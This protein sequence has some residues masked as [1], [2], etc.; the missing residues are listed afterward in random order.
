MTAPASAVAFDAFYRAE[1]AR[2]NGFFRRKVG[3]DEAA[4][5]TQEAFMRFYGS[6]RFATLECPRAYLATVARNIWLNRIRQQ[7]RRGILYPLDEERE[8]ATPP[9]QER[10]FEGKELRRAYWRALRPL[11]RKTRRIFL[12]HRLRGMTYRDIADELGISC[13]AVEKRIERALARCRKVAARH[14]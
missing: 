4:D 11:S 1:H 8:A 2:V 5:L 12:M 14:T 9:E 3:R 7:K 10:R 6:G 13:K